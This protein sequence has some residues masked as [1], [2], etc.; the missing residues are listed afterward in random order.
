MKD[1]GKVATIIDLSASVISLLTSI[2]A[3]KTTTKG[4]K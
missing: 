2:V 4:K 3:L 1:V